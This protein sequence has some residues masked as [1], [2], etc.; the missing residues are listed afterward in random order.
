MFWSHRGE[1]C[2]FDTMLT[3]FGLKSEA[4]DRLA[5]IVRGA[6]TARLELSPEAAGFLAFSLGLSRLFDD[7]L[8]QLQV[9]LTF[10]DAVYLWCRDAS[11]ETHNWPSK[12]AEE[13][14]EFIELHRDC[15]PARATGCRSHDSDERCRDLPKLSESEI[16]AKLTGM[17]ISDPHFSEQYMRD[18][19]VRIVTMGRRIIGKW[20][21]KDGKLC[22]E[23]PKPE[24]SRCKEVWHSGDKYQFR[25]EGDPVL[26]DVV[27]Q[28]QQQRGW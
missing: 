6:D 27:L 25:V 16:R 1:T 8:V 19:A 7:D 18:G 21:V 28:K 11:A 17:E 12:T 26:Y 9:G 5:M 22:I 4:L 23:A 14:H 20:H 15:R 24:D 3:E 2:T 13:S 10:Y